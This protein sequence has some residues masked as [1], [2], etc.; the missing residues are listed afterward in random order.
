MIGLVGQAVTAAVTGV[1]EAVVS[2]QAGAPVSSPRE[3]AGAAD[4]TGPASITLGDKTI[5]VKA[6][7]DGV[8]VSLTVREPGSAPDIHTL[9]VGSDGSVELRGTG[10][11]ENEVPAEVVS[12]HGPADSSPA[13]P[14]GPGSTGGPGPDQALP[15]S[16]Q[17]P[18]VPDPEP[19]PSGINDSPPQV[20]AER[21]GE[22][23]DPVPHPHPL[24]AG[25]SNDR[26]AQVA[27]QLS[28]PAAWPPPDDG[29]LALIGD[30]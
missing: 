12:A 14:A 2:A 24:P 3:P 22:Q 8:S 30:Q 10:G 15:G 27:P 20:A 13:V 7:A 23:P 16:D 29:V 17:A 28:A 11:P 6:G 9:D 1:V 4:V 19:E 21:E 18:R 5:E 25:A 26:G